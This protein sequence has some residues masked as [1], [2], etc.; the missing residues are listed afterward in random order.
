MRTLNLREIA[1]NLELGQDGWWISQHL[2][3]IS[4]SEEGNA[5]CFSVEDSSFWFG[6]R[7]DC[8]LTAIQLFPPSGTLFDV[9][10]GNGYV[11]RA[12]QEGG[13]EV[14]LVEPG[15]DGVRNALQRGIHHVV[16]ATLEDVGLLPETLPAVGL[17]DVIEHVHDD[18]GFLIGIHRLLVPGGRVYIT[19]PA[20]Q[21]LWSDVDIQ[22]G[23]SRRYT[24]SG[25]RRLLENAGCTVEFATY[26]FGFLPL[27]IFLRRALPYRLGLESAGSNFRSEH[28]IG[29]TL[30]G[31]IVRMLTRRELSRI[32]GLRPLR[33][34]GSCLVVGRKR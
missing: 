1:P 3:D 10:G 26:F 8:I 20:Y 27:L 13:L 11:A 16:H 9:G 18:S 6:H 22:A 33:M 2:S 21:W 4:Y 28:E 29:H 23:H 15:I 30:V 32:A 24:V 31:R 17:F 19:V 5:L 34:G 12:I 14:V 7:N 25:L